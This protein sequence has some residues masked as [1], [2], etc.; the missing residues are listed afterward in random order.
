VDFVAREEVQ[1]LVRAQQNLLAAVAKYAW[2]QGAED[3]AHVIHHALGLE[4]EPAAAEAARGLLHMHPGDRD[5]DKVAEAARLVKERLDKLAIAGVEPT[6]EDLGA[7]NLAPPVDDD[8]R[9]RM[10]RNSRY[11]VLRYGRG[12]GETEALER[13]DA[14]Y[15]QE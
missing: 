8:L 10:I 14:T 7:W 13:I 6:S 1:E 4:H 15:S 5:P 2:A 12:V 9:K 3:A 11:F